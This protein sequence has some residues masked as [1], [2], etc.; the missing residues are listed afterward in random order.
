V[1]SPPRLPKYVF[2]KASQEDSASPN[3]TAGQR[4]SALDSLRGV[5]PR[6]LRSVG[7]GVVAGT[8]VA[9]LITSPAAAAPD[10]VGMQHGDVGASV[11]YWQER[12]NQ[13]LEAKKRMRSLLPLEEDG[14]FGPKTEAATEYLQEQANLPADGVVTDETLALSF[15]GYI[16]MGMDDRP[17]SL[18]EEG[19]WI[20]W[21]QFRVNGWLRIHHYPTSALAVD[22]I[23]GPRS[24][25]A[26]RYVGRTVGVKNPGNTV[27]VWRHLPA[28]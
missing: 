5:K 3:R 7:S 13:M 23:Y 10:R 16:S 18:G 21:F 6:L 2:S 12:L 17:Y 26:T 19:I 9:M 11:R 28:R 24:A 20:A 1:D 4:F 8:L 22:G 25:A 27:R 14:V 15:D